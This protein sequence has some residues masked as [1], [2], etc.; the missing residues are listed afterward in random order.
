M[1]LAD[2]LV[3]PAGDLHLIAAALLGIVSVVLLISLL[4]VHPFLALI[5]GSAVLGV[6]AGMPAAKIVDS[7][8]AGVGSTVGS[9][10]L[11]IALGAMIG[12][13]ATSNAPRAREPTGSHN[14]PAARRSMSATGSIIVSTVGANRGRFAR[15]TPPAR[16]ST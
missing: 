10:G 6:V 13:P 14:S 12:A 16:G 15:A 7:F 9:V 8:T 4:R 5:F 3:A 11:L 2:Q 1:F